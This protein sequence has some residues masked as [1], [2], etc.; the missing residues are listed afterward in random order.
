MYKKNEACVSY[1]GSSLP[2]PQVFVTLDKVKIY[3]L[4]YLPLE[5]FLRDKSCNGVNFEF[6]I[7]DLHFF[8]IA[9]VA[10]C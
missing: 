3:P 7:A 2:F 10:L 8:E 4:Y 1:N 6:Q 9:P 5:T